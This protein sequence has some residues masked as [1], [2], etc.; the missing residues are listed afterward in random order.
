M[1]LRPVLP[2]PSLFLGFRRSARRGL[3][4][5]PEEWLL[6]GGA[7]PSPARLIAGLVEWHGV[8]LAG[9]TVGIDEDSVL[10]RGGRRHGH[11]QQE[12]D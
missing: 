2:A 9:G 6:T 3:D 12:R 11:E 4:P 1:T 5:L 7:S 8:L 10:L